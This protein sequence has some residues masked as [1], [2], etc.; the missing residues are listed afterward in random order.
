MIT[1]LTSFFSLGNKV[2]F[3]GTPDKNGCLIVQY[4]NSCITHVILPRTSTSENS[5]VVNTWLYWS[6]IS[7][8][9]VVALL[10]YINGKH[11]RLCQDG[12]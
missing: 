10:F 6:G 2:K 9:V 4:N 3:S 1:G 11:L 7:V 5:Q 12:Q 8:V